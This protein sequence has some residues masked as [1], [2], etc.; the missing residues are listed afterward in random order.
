[1]RPQQRWLGVNLGHW[2]GCLEWYLT[3]IKRPR[4]LWTKTRHSVR[5]ISSNLILDTEKNL[6]PHDTEMERSS[7]DVIVLNICPG[8]PLVKLLFSRPWC[9]TFYMA[10]CHTPVIP[11]ISLWASPRSENRKLFS[12]ITGQILL[13]IIA[14]MCLMPDTQNCGLCMHPECRERFPRHRRLA[15]STCIMAR[16]LRTCRDACRDR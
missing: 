15:I 9:K 5:V 16:A 1:M 14:T 6:L 8:S 2:S 12:T 4:T 10:P 13:G 11:D 3:A 7:F